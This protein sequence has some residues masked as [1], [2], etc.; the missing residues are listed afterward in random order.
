MEVI[1]SADFIFTWNWTDLKVER[2]WR[3][4]PFILFCLEK[5]MEPI[6]R[7]YALLSRSEIIPKAHWTVRKSIDGV[8]RSITLACAIV[9]LIVMGCLLFT[10]VRNSWLALH[11][12]GSDF[13][14]SRKWNPVT[15]QFGALSSVYGTLISTLIALILAVPTSMATA[16]FLVEFAPSTVGRLAGHAIEMLALAVN[17]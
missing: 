3:I 5:F 2:A 11:T 8:F 17:V 9:I 16:T 7:E 10:L 1:P 13:L 15:Q 6:Q 12:F 14:T 4:P